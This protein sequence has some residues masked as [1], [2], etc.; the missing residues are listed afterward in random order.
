M[1]KLQQGVCACVV[2]PSGAH[3]A[4]LGEREI[5]TNIIKSNS[6]LFILF[7]FLLPF[8]SDANF[9]ITTS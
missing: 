3:S 2:F 1:E 5:L 6:R 7:F 4:I 8:D 9:P